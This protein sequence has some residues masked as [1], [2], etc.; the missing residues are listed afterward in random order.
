MSK[1]DVAA[2]ILWLGVTLYAVFGGADFGGGMWDLLAGQGERGQRARRLIDHS[3]APVWEANHVWL[4][5][6]LVVLWTAFPTVFSAIMTTV[7]YFGG[8]ARGTERAH[9][10][11]SRCNV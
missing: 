1:A 9:R 4:I 10:V 3:I 6:V 11:R 2:A 7:L 5:F 8:F